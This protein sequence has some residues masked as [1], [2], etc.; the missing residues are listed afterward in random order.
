MKQGMLTRRKYVCR[1][2]HVRTS[3]NTVIRPDRHGTQSVRCMDCEREN[4]KKMRYGLSADQWLELFLSQ[5]K[6]CAVCKTAAPGAKG[7][8][9]DHDHKTELVRGIVCAS[10]NKA[11]GFARDSVEILQQLIIYLQRRSNASFN[12]QDQ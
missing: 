3:D 9:V 6:C 1:N 11:L 10:C 5:G 7:W 8:H 4:K 2:G 12:D